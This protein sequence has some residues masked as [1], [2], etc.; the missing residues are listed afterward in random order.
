MVLK[1]HGLYIVDDFP[2]S[3]YTVIKDEARKSQA[4]WSP[5]D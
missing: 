4:A 1:L 2:Y 5:G 3:S